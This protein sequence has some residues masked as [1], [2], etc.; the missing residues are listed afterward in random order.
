MENR[1][2]NL[3]SSSGSKSSIIKGMP[4]HVVWGIPKNLKAPAVIVT[5]YGPDPEKWVDDFKRRKR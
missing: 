2:L 5:A 4:I 1:F 3:A